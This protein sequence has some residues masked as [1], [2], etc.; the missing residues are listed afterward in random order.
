[1]QD[2]AQVEHEQRIQLNDLEHDILAVLAWHQQQAHQ[3]AQVRPPVLGQDAANAPLL[4]LVEHVE[5]VT[6][7]VVPADR[8]GPRDAIITRACDRP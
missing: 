5:P 1:M 7:V 8:L 2:V 3:R 6:I 4:P